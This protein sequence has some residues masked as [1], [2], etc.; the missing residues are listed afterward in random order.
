MKLHSPVSCFFLQ[1]KSVQKKVFQKKV[2]LFLIEQINC[3]SN[4]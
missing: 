2:F 1:N 4:Q 3:L